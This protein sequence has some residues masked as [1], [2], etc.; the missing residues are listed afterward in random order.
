MTDF[1][2]KPLILNDPIS[3]RNGDPEL[4]RLGFE[5]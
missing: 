3:D 2:L 1:I 4:S 5:A